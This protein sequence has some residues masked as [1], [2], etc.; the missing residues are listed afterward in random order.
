MENYLRTYCEID[1]D[2]ILQNILNIKEKAGKD[3]KLMAVIKADGYG[4]GANEIGHYIKDVVDYFGVAT[5]EE[6]VELRKADLHLPILILGYNS[7]SLYHLNLEYDVDQT[8]YSWETAQ[9]MSEIAVKMGKT[10]RIHIALDTGMTRIG[11]SPDEEGLEIVKEIQKLPSLKIEGLFTHFSC[12]DMTDK[13]YTFAQME[14]YDSFVQLLEK[15]HIEIPTKHICNSA[16]IM[17][18]DHHRYDM[19]R[20]GIITYGLYPSDEVD[21]TALALTPALSWKSHVVNIM[22]P[23]MNRGISYG[24]TYVTD[25]PCRIATVSI[26]YADGYPRSLSNKG[27]VLIRGKKAPIAGRVCMDQMMVDITEIPDVEIEDIVTLIGTD[28]DQRISVEDMADLSGSF[29][30]EFVCDI[31]KRVPR[32][33][34]SEA[35]A[36]SKKN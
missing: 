7:P 21:M 18:F 29:N 31:S 15:N 6:A 1:L 9:K 27:W 24:A 20:S 12:A 30:Y 36:I 3:V 5:I 35:E 8:I 19:V 11:I 33:Y 22:E 25:H 4:H 34:L 28:G 26:G 2:A 23:K 16:G 17:E 32:I 13:G 10:A 14:R